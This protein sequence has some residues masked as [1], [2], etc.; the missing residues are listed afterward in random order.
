[1]TVSVFGNNG[2]GESSSSSTTSAAAAATTDFFYEVLH[3]IPSLS[4][5]YSHLVDVA[6]M[7]RR[8]KRS[9]HGLS[10]STAVGIVLFVFIVS[11]IA[12]F[13]LYPQEP[14][15]K[16]LDAVSTL[17]SFGQA[18]TAKPTVRPTSSS[19]PWD[20]TTVAT[21]STRSTKSSSY[22]SS[23]S[24]A[25]HGSMLSMYLGDADVETLSRS[26]APLTE[27]QRLVDWL[28]PIVGGGTRR[29]AGGGG[30]EGDLTTVGLDEDDDDDE[31]DEI[32][33]SSLLS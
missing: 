15:T 26:G 9:S 30:T 3:E 23:A 18:K 21:A 10:W 25:S 32:T 22:S 33:S 6:T 17:S 1:M 16:L 29:G 14:S 12:V 28:V 11:T 19:S 13:M 2:S 27:Q 4:P 5:R 8:N 24:A 31:Y 20:A 7:S